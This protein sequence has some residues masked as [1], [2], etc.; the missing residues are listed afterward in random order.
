MEPAMK[1]RGATGPV[2]FRNQPSVRLAPATSNPRRQRSEP[3]RLALRLHGMHPFCLPPLPMQICLRVLGVLLLA[4]PPALAQRV[5]CTD[6]QAGPYPCASIDLL[7]H[8]PLSFFG[9]TSGNT[10]WGW[11]DPETGRE[12]AIMGLDVGAA[13]L[14]VTI[15]TA[16]VY[17]GMVRAQTQ[18]SLWREF[19]VM[20]D[21]V[22]IVSEASG[23]GMQVFDLR[24]LRNVANPPVDFTPDV[25]YT[26]VGPSHNVATNEESGFVYIVG[27]RGNSQI[28][29]AGGLHMVDARNPAAP[30]FAGC[31]AEDGYTHDVQCI[32]YDGPDTRFTG[33]EICFAYNV[34]TVTIVDVTDKANPMMLSQGVYPLVGYV[35]QGWLTEDRRY[36]LVDDEFDEM[37]FRINARTIVMNVEDLTNPVFAFEYIADFPS[38]DHNQ[39]VAGQY[40]F[41]SNYT[42]GLRVLDLT[43]IDEGIL[44]EVA[45]FDTFPEN[46]EPVFQGS[47]NN[48][49]YFASGTVVV[50]DIDRGLFLVQPLIP[51]WPTGRDPLEFPVPGGFEVGRAFPNPFVDRARLIVRVERRQHV[52]ARVYDAIGRRVAD[53][54][55]GQMESRAEYPLAFQPHNLP[56][57][58]YFIRVEGEDFAETRRVTLVR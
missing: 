17:V 38:I 10:G 39:Y 5:P 16:P 49:P 32:I 44:E 14:D 28:P 2:A 36:I 48:F 12:Y 40:V 58:V 55:D 23:H 20:R 4:M 57:G 56:A 21:H 47:W 35:H 9:A 6:G 54:F 18:P 27:A 22:Y 26:L 3:S 52:R 24:R 1:A 11:T 42:A 46:N 53:L 15:P 31:F 43:R 41:Q 19:K 51:N 30:V 29:C 37:N 7:A 25:V 34:N 50:S 13:F 33:R 45:Y 8:R